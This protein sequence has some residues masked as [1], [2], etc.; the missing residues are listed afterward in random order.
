M[1]VEAEKDGVKVEFETT[2]HPVWQAL[3]QLERKR[4]DELMKRR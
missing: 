2:G 4:I 1:R 3:N